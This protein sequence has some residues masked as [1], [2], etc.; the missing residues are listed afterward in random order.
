MDRAAQVLEEVVAAGGPS[1][2]LPA[3][4]LLSTFNPSSRGA[5]QLV[6]LLHRCSLSSPAVAA[7]LQKELELSGLTF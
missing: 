2:M 4:R 3:V 1:S 7:L 5:V 6:R